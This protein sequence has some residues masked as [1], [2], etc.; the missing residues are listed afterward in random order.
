MGQFGPL[1]HLS[2]AT[3]DLVSDQFGH[4][5]EIGGS[6][7]TTDTVSM[8][9][10]K[11]VHPTFQDKSNY[12]QWFSVAD[13]EICGGDHIGHHQLSQHRINGQK[14]SIDFRHCGAG[15]FDSHHV[16]RERINCSIWAVDL[17]EANMGSKWCGHKMTAP[18]HPSEHQ[19][20]KI[21]RWFCLWVVLA[22]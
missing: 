13:T 10:T 4:L 3:V 15:H 16:I 6:K 12:N 19:R 9:W 7:W 14:L 18:Y 5:A 8:G 11:S 20:V 2:G 21:A 1:P 22:Y 17:V